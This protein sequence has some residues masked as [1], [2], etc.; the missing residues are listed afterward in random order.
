VA[1]V[2]SILLKCYFGAYLDE[3][4]ETSKMPLRFLQNQVSFIGSSGDSISFY[5]SPHGFLYG[6]HG[7][8]FVRQKAVAGKPK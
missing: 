5:A 1:I 4:K 7:D 6:P 8:C 2:F 3:R